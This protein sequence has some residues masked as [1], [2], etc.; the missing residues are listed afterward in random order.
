[1]LIEPLTH[2]RH[3]LRK[4]ACRNSDQHGSHDPLHPNT[5]LGIVEGASPNGLLSDIRQI[6]DGF[7]ARIALLNDLSNGQQRASPANG[8]PKPPV[9]H[10]AALNRAARAAA[11][12]YAR[13]QFCGRKHR[14]VCGLLLASAAVS[15]LPRTDSYH[16]PSSCRAPILSSRRASAMLSSKS[17]GPAI[18]RL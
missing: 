13:R 17:S 10:T 8:V 15:N 2:P 9:D 1:M 3:L 14:A 16:C 12:R 5:V 7:E 11:F 18:C 4:F 6:P